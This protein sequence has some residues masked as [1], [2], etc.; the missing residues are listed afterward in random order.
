VNN[1][2]LNKLSVGEKKEQ[3]IAIML[4]TILIVKEEIE[5]KRR[6]TEEIYEKVKLGKNLSQADAEFLNRE[7]SKY[8]VKN[9]NYTKLMRR[10]TTPPV[11][12]VLAQAIIESGWGTSRFF[13]EANNV[14][15]IWSF[16]ENEPRVPSKSGYRGGKRVF[17]KKYT[18]LKECLED[19]L[20]KMAVLP[21]YKVFR[22]ELLKTDNYI[23]LTKHL[24]NYSELR[25][26]YVARLNSLISKNSL[27]SYEEYTLKR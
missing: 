16:N 23:Y 21:H 20:Y 7:F 6:K 18:S 24:E 8:K 17:L 27:D 12:I 3:F 4:P 11:S 22:D 26:E 10:L 19:Y 5:G 9:G 15:G 1:Y 14:F 13:K 2:D 25:G